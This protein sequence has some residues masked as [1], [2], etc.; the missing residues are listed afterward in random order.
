MEKLIFLKQ[1]DFNKWFDS[2]S[3]NNYMNG[4]KPEKF[5]CMVVSIEI[6]ERT[7]KDSIYFECVYIEDFNNEYLVVK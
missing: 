7:V 5:P 2:C 6:R 4:Q 1:E 3:R